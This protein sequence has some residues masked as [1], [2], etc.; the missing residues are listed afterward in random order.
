[1]SKKT[2][3]DMDC[4]LADFIK[5]F[6]ETIDHGGLSRAKFD[7]YKHHVL[8]Y[9]DW[10]YKMPPMADAKKMVDYL[11]KNGHDLWILSAAPKWQHD[12]A[13]QKIRWLQKHFPIIKSNQ[14]IITERSEKKR[15]AAGGHILIDDYIKNIREW[16]NAGGI[17]IKHTSADS[18][19]DM[20][21]KDKQ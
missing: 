6:N 10:W 16:T 20:L 4:V 3:L 13:N 17:G 15:Y 18:T 14:I 19:I 21:E 11:H 2:Y 8:E 7:E 5:H 1:M 9:K 12:A